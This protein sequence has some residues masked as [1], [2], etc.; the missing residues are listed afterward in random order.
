MVQLLLVQLLLLLSL[1][2]LMLLMHLFQW[3]PLACWR[4]A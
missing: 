1:L 4:R 2:L 3:R